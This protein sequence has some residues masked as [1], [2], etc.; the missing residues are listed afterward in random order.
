MVI[1]LREKLDINKKY[2]TFQRK[3][4]SQLWTHL[5]KSVTERFLIYTRTYYIC[6]ETKTR[7]FPANVVNGGQNTFWKYFVILD[8]LFWVIRIT[9]N[10]MG[11]CNI[12]WLISNIVRKYKIEI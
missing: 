1:T 9:Q 10:T 4:Y 7:H 6:E 8:E 11:Y 2:C 12:R 5:L 3:D